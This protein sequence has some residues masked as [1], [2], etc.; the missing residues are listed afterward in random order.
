MVSNVGLISRLHQLRE[1]VLGKLKSKLM[2]CV[3]RGELD[4]VI[5]EERFR[6]HCVELYC[7]CIF[8]TW[9]LTLTASSST[10]STTRS[11]NSVMS[12][13]TLHGQ[14]SFSALCRTRAL[15]CFVRLIMVSI[16]V[17]FS[18]RRMASLSHRAR[19]SVSV[20]SLMFP[21]HKT[22]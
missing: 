8:L 20:S 21:V 4:M 14:T 5:S 18:H 1:Q 2:S 9:N 11:Q 13:L 6:I 15:W 10:I 3:P 22:T 17:V 7:T 19:I 12:S 16:M